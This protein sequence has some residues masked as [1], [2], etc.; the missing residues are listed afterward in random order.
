LSEILYWGIDLGTTYSALTCFNSKKHTVTRCTELIPSF[1]DLNTNEVGAKVKAAVYNNSVS[2]SSEVFAG[3]KVD[4]FT[5]SAGRVPRIASTKVLECLTKE[6]QG[7][8][9]V[10]TVPAYFNDAQRRA[11]RES[12]AKAGISVKALINEPTSAAVAYKHYHPCEEGMF[13][14][15][16]LGGGTFDITI[17]D[18]CGDTID[19]IATDGLKI[20]GNDLNKAIRSYL[21]KKA[22]IPLHTVSEQLGNHYLELAEEAKISIQ[23]TKRDYIF[24][25]VDRVAALSPEEYMR[26]VQDVFGI[27]IVKL[28]GLLARYE[29]QPD[30]YSILLVGG[31]TRDPYL[32]KLLSQVKKPLPVDYDP[33]FL[34]AEGSSIY[35][36]M[37]DN[38]LLRENLSDV[39]KALSV[40][41]DK[42]SLRKLIPPNS[43][44]PAVESWLF[45]NI[46][47]AQT[48]RIRLHQ[49]NSSLPT[50]D[51]Y[52]GT[53]EYRYSEPM[54]AFEGYIFVTLSVDK[55]GIL[56]ATAREPLGRLERLQLYV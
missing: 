41:L 30:E 38:E 20:G 8:N 18:Y 54:K 32:Q 17:V 53:L 39:T 50:E 51:S 12:A 3:F 36:Y 10:I 27:T 15:Y 7:I 21:Y 22:G 42:N 48:V 47:D 2:D 29:L 1:V 9:A 43:S 40:Q 52:I 55:D 46:E 28:K 45:T 16:D 19:V 33:D 5:G 35:S 49:T 23:K 13:I 14:V 31:S 56:K 24:R 44:L 34:V 6:H 4:M 26:I 25:F 11:T 37:L